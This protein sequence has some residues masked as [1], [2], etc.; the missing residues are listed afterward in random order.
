MPEVV[1][2]FVLAVRD[3]HSFI[4]IVFIKSREW[5]YNAQTSHFKMA[6]IAGNSM[7][8]TIAWR[9]LYTDN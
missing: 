9:E 1:R 5:H 2:I 7:I 4:A 8:K 6:A 3:S